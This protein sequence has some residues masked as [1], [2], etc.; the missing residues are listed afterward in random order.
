MIRTI[1]A[2]ARFAEVAATAAG[3]LSQSSRLSLVALSRSEEIASKALMTEA[4]A[5]SGHGSISFLSLD[6]P[7]LV[8]AKAARELKDF[9][10]NLWRA[11]TATGDRHPAAGALL[12]KAEQLTSSF[13]K[14]DTRVV[15]FTLNPNLSFGLPNGVRTVT[16]F[17]DEALK[18]DRL[19]PAEFVK[20]G[21]MSE[22][23]K[24]P[25]MKFVVK[26]GLG[27]EGKNTRF[28]GFMEFREG[29]RRR[30]H[31]PVLSEL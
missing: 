21:P 9:G 10:G 5:G 4:R 28:L 2:L 15:E 3:D 16:P 27:R 18:L 8:V 20:R 14:L 29:A 7:A 6:D 26:D 11:G 12:N 1:P 30:V 31:I 22:F 23:L 17:V 24:D 25:W 19:V 13:A